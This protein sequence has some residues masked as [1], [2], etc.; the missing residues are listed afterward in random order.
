MLKEKVC[1]WIPVVVEDALCSLG[2]DVEEYTFP[3]ISNSVLKSARGIND[4]QMAMLL[5]PWK[6]GHRF[7]IESK[8]MDDVKK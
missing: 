8:N 1:S 7:W 2:K 6:H 3:R 4:P 5:L